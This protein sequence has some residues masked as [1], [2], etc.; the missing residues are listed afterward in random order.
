MNFR[1]N[2]NTPSQKYPKISS[3]NK[4][5]SKIPRKRNFNNVINYNRKYV[6]N[7]YSRP[8]SKLPSIYKKKRSNE[9]QIDTIIFPRNRRIKKYNNVKLP[10]IL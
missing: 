10:K 6:R 5:I 1:Y 4:N 3:Y 8:V 9:S 2:V 7:N